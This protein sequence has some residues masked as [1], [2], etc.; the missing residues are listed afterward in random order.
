[1]GT[2]I[3]QTAKDRIQLFSAED[4]VLKSNLV[5]GRVPKGTTTIQ[6][7]LASGRIVTGSHDGDVFVIWAADH[8]VRGA[9]L[10][11][12]QADGSVIAAAS[13]PTQF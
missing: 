9:Q 13:A 5:V 1:M 11:A 6:A 4:A 10:T 12:T 3:E 2:Q 8:S 7:Q